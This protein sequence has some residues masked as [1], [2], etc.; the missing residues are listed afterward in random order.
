LPLSPALLLQNIN[1]VICVNCSPFTRDYTRE[2][3]I[4]HVCLFIYVQ[5]CVDDITF[6][7]FFK[8]DDARRRGHSKKLF[9]R[10]S[11]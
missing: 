9:K 11:R 5:V 3:T 1:V 8:F 6:D 4:L 7:T 2:N 10:R